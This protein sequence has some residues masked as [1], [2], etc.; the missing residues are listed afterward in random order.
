MS[1]KKKL[2]KNKFSYNLFLYDKMTMTI[3]FFFFIE[4]QQHH[5]NVDLVPP[6]TTGKE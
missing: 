3:I 6:S 1:F 5:D 4:K 2:L